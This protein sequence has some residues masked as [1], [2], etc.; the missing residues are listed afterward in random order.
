MPPSA[1]RPSVTRNHASPSIVRNP[2]ALCHQSRQHPKAQIHNANQG[3]RCESLNPE[4]RDNPTPARFALFRNGVTTASNS[5]SVKQS[6]KKCVTTKSN[7]PVSK[8]MRA[9]PTRKFI[10]EARSLAPFG[11]LDHSRTQVDRVHPGFW[12]A[13]HKLRGK[14]AVA[15]T[16]NQHASSIGHLIQKFQTPPFQ[17]PPKRQLLQRLVPA[18]NSVAIHL[19][20]ILHVLN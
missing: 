11:N 3:L 17:R 15:I 1:R 20:V 9:S 6:R 12:I 5:P 19:L 8:T 18:G 2:V 10:C 16:Q 14:R 13:S 7:F 4:F